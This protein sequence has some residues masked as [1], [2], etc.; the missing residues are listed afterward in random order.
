LPKFLF[1]TTALTAVL[2]A[3]CGG[4]DEE[5]PAGTGSPPSSVCAQD[6]NNVVFTPQQGDYFPVIVSSDLAVGE[7][8]FVAGLLD[9]DG[10]PVTGGQLHFRFYCFT[11]SGDHIDKTETDAQALSITRSV[12]HTHDD[13]TVEAHEAGE[14]GVHVATIGFDA[15]GKW[16]VDV[17]ALWTASRSQ[18]NRPP[19][20]SGNRASHRQSATGAAERAADP[21]GRDRHP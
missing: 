19:S 20:A 7:N 15:D 6:L 3:A 2:L 8:R 1:V 5:T 18:P 9:N 4:G 16:G 13:G 17:V 12:T 11:D 21:Q 14:L 10:E